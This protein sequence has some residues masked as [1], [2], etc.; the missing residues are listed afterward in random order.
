MSE[1]LIIISYSPIVGLWSWEV[2]VGRERGYG[3][4]KEYPDAET[5]AR[6]MAKR[7]GAEL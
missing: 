6:D 5:S 7:M 4:E 3:Y 2:R 1:I